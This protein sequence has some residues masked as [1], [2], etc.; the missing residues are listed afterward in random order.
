MDD[1]RHAFYSDIRQKRMS[2]PRPRSVSQKRPKV[3]RLPGDFIDRRSTSEYRSGPVLRYILE[4]VVGMLPK[5]QNWKEFLALSDKER[6]TVLQRYFGEEK[7]QVRDVAEELGAPSPAAVQAWAK[8]L[9]LSVRELRGETSPKPEPEPEVV[10]VRG[11]SVAMAE[12][13]TGAELAGQ[14]L[15]LAEMLGSDS[16][17]SREYVLSLELYQQPQVHRAEV[18]DTRV[19][20]FKDVHTDEAAPTSED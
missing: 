10:T 5:P 12:E 17:G 20:E 13:G 19:H 18:V 11:L 2:L 8:K 4:G 16:L 14:L 6:S 3:L 1:I 7:L 15:T 9:K